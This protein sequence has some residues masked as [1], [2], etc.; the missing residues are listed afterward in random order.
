MLVVV[1]VVIV[2]QVLVVLGAVPGRMRDSV[3]RT[4]C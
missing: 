3:R 2:V 4:G 1:V